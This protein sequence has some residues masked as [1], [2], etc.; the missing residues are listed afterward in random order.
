MFRADES[1]QSKEEMEQLLQATNEMLETKAK[2]M[3]LSSLNVRSILHHLIKY[4]STIDVLLGIRE[5]D[6]LPT[7]RNTRSRKKPGE[8]G[9]VPS[10]A[11]QTPKKVS[12]IIKFLLK[13]IFFFSLH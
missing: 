9:S 8:N 6:D 4:P 11:T 13:L 10:S 1:L 12:N 7:V 3:N 5:S 2:S